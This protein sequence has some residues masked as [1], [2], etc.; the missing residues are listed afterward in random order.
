MFGKERVIRC[1]RKVRG[2]HVTIWASLRRDDG[3][4]HTVKPAHLV[5]KAFI[6]PRPSGH[7]ARHLDGNGDNNTPDNLAW[8]TQAE[9]IMDAVRHGTAPRAPGVR[10]VKA[11]LTED[12]VQE[13]RLRLLC[14]ERPGKIA[15][16]Y[17]LHISAIRF[18]ENLQ[19]WRHLP[20]PVLG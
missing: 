3:S 13:I 15:P 6:G 19:T 5:L 12:Q 4:Y 20:H 11:K 14:G 10:N 2:Q 17:G 8:G 9:N 1:A 18:I 16:D 7:V